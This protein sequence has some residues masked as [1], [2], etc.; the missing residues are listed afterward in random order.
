[1]SAVHLVHVGKTYDGGVEAVKDVTLTVKEGEFVAFLGPSGCGKTTTLRCIAGLEHP[2]RG[3]IRF[4]DTVVVNSEKKVFVP[5][6]GR[7]IGMVFQSYAVWPHMTVFENVAFPLRIKKV[8]KAEIERRVREA[9]RLTKIEN[10]ADRYPTQLSGGQQQRVAV[11][12]AIVGNPRVLLF[13]EPLSNLDAKLRDEMRFEISRLQREL[14]ITTIYVTHDQSEA[15]VMADR[16][17]VMREGRVAQIGTPEEI[18][19]HPADTFVASFVGDANLIPVRVAGPLE[20][21]RVPVQV[22]DGQLRL[23]ASV[24]GDLPAGDLVCLIRPENVLPAPGQDGEDVYTATV[25]R[26]TYMGS[27]VEYELDVL[28]VKLVMRTHPNGR[29]APGQRLP[30]RLNP[31]HCVLLSESGGGD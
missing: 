14:G 26:R 2:T 11:S 25:V 22:R 31:E 10:L 8:P 4:G 17:V 7:D 19:A 3:E 9:L 20:G 24:R 18:Y 6:E 15:M 29:T 1:M 12:R 13:D 16:V 30:V 27:Q 5:P 28:G 23:T 21:G